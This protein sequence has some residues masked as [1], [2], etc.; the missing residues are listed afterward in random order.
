M[1]GNNALLYSCLARNNDLVEYLIKKAGADPIIMNDNKL[2]LLLMA[3][4]KCQI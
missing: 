1:G 3:T 2:N 4:K